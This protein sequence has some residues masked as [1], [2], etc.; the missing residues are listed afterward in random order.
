MRTILLLALAASVPF[1]LSADPATPT[2]SVDRTPSHLRTSI[3]KQFLWGAPYYPEQGELATLDLDAKRMRAAGMNTVRMAEFAWELMEPQEGHYDFSL[4]DEAIARLGAKGINTILCTPTATPP[5]WLT[6]EHPEI[7]RV[8]D[9]GVQQLHGSRQQANPCSDVYREYSR[10]ITRAMAEHY[11]DN[12]YV[13]GWQTDNE[14]NCGYAEDY[15]EQ[16][17]LSWVTF[18]KEKFHDD[19]NALNRTWGTVFWDQTCSHFEDVP[20]PTPLRPTH[21]NPAHRLDYF[22]FI[23]WAVTRFQHD[24]VEILRATQ[25]RWW[26]T[27][28][29]LFK[30]I[31]YRGQFGRDL[32][33]LGY[34]A[35]P[36]FAWD[37]TK[38]Y[39]SHAWVLDAAR[40]WTGNFFIPEHQGGP[41]GQTD[42]FQ[43]NPEPGE[44]RNLL[45]T[46]VAHGADSVMIFRWRTARFGAE[47]Y[48]TGILDHDNVPRRRYEEAK[49]FG[50]EMARVGPAVLGTHVAIDVALAATDFDNTYGHQALSLG[51]PSPND[52][53]FDVHNRFWQAGYRVGVVAPGDTLEGLKLYIL[54]H[55]ALIDPAWVPQL[56]AWVQAGGVLVIGARSGTKDL[57]NNVVTDALP[58]VLRPLV[59]AIVVEYG[60]QNRPEQRPLEIAIGGQPVLSRDWYEQLE[61]DEGTG[62]WLRWATRHLAGTPAATIRKVGHGHVIY[63]GTYLNGDIGQALLPELVKLAGLEPALPG[64]PP[65]VEVVRRETS[66]RTLWFVM[67][68][69]EDARTVS[70]PAGHDLISDREVGGDLN[71]PA[72]EVA[73]IETP[74]IAH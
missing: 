18:L 33:V 44:M 31:D 19:I 60:R 20:L 55:L 58:G 15:S 54:P 41:G 3:F 63:V 14:L 72:R 62:V 40:A 34:D 22:R 69:N 52:V 47:E 70:V 27:H 46:S 50:N 30:L 59:G 67:N 2:S 48:W 61:P 8:D 36:M 66:D 35:Y 24:Q 65:G 39:P 23:S 12:P 73:V 28:N 13:I 74:V 5:R 53:A 43:D 10:R 37:P 56:E 9:R 26:I 11:R 45:Y 17:R 71:L 1:G 6:I 4:F 16:T 38:R 68:H 64:A 51:L 49:R 25:P 21:L 7:L 57:D 32:D 42:Y 29:G